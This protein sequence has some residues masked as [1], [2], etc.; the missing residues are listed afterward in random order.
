MKIEIGK[1]ARRQAERASSWWRENRMHVPGLLD[2]ELERALQLLLV[3]PNAGVSYATARRPGLR[4]LLLPKTE[5]HV[6]FAFERGG[7]VIVI[8]S[9]WGARR[10]RGPRLQSALTPPDQRPPC[11]APG[12][13]SCVRSRP[14]PADGART[15]GAVS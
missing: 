8:H 15:P 3:M 14:R 12:G 4:R 6:Y 1:Q 13:L 2:A 7:T 10:A 11:H 9:L 5:Y